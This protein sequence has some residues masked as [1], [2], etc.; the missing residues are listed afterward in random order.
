MSYLKFM[1]IPLTAGVAQSRDACTSV[2]TQRPRMCR[3]A[4]GFF[5]TC[6]S[7]HDH[8]SPAISNTHTWLIHTLE[9]DLQA[10]DWQ[11]LVVELKHPSQLCHQPWREQLFPFKPRNRDETQPVIRCSTVVFCGANGRL[12]NNC[13]LFCFFESINAVK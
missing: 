5:V 12:M 7:Q 11:T 1:L 3:C 2:H 6:L 13:S 9:L 8:L 4:S 10:E